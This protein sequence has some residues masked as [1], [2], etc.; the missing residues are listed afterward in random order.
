[1][2]FKG[3]GPYG[4]LF[5]HEGAEEVFE[6]VSGYRGA[7]FCCGTDVVDGFGFGGEGSAGGS[8]GGGEIFWGEALAGQG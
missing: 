5:G 8:D 7:V 6:E 3:Y 4:A 1:M 2:V